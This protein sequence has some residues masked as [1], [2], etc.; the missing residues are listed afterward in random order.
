MPIDNNTPMASVKKPTSPLSAPQV[1]PAQ[2]K[3]Q[4]ENFLECI[5]KYN[6]Y[7]KALK[8]ATT[9]QEVGGQL[10]QIAELAEQAVVNEADDWFDSHTLKRNMKEIKSYATD[11][12]KLATEA[13]TINQRMTALYDDMG[14][15]LERYFEIPDEEMAQ[16]VTNSDDTVSMTSPSRDKVPAVEEAK[17]AEDAL[18]PNNQG[19]PAHNPSEPALPSRAEQGKTPK[20][21]ALTLRAIQLIHKRL[22]LTNPDMAKKFAKLPPHRMEDVVWKL[23]K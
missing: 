20:R 18:L 4:I 7:G 6:T 22:Q 12:V 16:D 3:M 8:R 21:D 9:M 23:V 11:F 14:R 15:I 1:N 10:A 13:D 5:A 17:V 19:L 2:Q